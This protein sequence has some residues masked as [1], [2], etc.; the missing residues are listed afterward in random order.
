MGV[1]T[2]V[3]GNV[4]ITGWAI[5]TSGISTSSSFQ[6]SYGGG[7]QDG[8]LT[9][10]NSNG[11]RLWSTYFGGTNSECPM[12][13][14]TDISGNVLITGW[15]ISTSGITT[16]GSHQPLFGGGG[17]DGFLTKFNVN[18]NRIW[19]TYY[20][21]SNSE[22]PLGIATDANDNVYI[23]G[24]AIST[25][26]ISTPGS[27]QPIFGGGGQDGFLAKFSSQNLGFSENEILSNIIVYPI[28]SSDKFNLILSQKLLGCNYFL[29]DY[30]G[31]FLKTDKIDAE[32]TIIDLSNFPS[33]I[34]FL[35]VGD[36][37]NQTIKLIK[38]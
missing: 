29:I 11:S 14:A 34:Y 20:G 3:S 31:N 19:S 30:L 35:R 10:F 9:K 24:W 7:S 16:S 36:D 37:L 18:G 8:F 6:A 23:T 26:G 4:F 33:G 12:G 27:S 5:S 28:P 15:V 1:A 25:S 2:D 32:K 22:C 17:Q 38:D 21:G 13:I